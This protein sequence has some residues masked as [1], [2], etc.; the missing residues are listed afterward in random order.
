MQDRESKARYWADKDEWRGTFFLWP[1]WGDGWQCISPRHHTPMVHVKR[2]GREGRGSTALCIS[3]VAIFSLH[4]C[5]LFQLIR[6][7]LPEASAHSIF[8]C[9]PRRLCHPVDRPVLSA[10][11]F[12][13]SLQDKFKNSWRPYVLR[14]SFPRQLCFYYFGLDQQVSELHCCY[15]CPFLWLLEQ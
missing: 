6:W 1:R 14:A 13:L 8:P 7:C 15:H 2:W 5:G 3:L 10:S 4:E 12:T 11:L 9:R